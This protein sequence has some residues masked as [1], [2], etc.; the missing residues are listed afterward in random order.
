MNRSNTFGLILV[1][2]TSGLA[3]GGCTGTEAPEAH[4][5]YVEADWIYVASPQAGWIVEQP[6][7]EGMDVEAGDILFRLDTQAQEAALAEANARIAQSGAQARNM[8]T[9][10]REAEIRALQARLDEARA[11]LTKAEAD[12]TRILPL[13]ERGLEPQARGDTVS[14]EADMAAAAVAALTQDIAVARQA[15]RPAEREAADAL[16]VSAEAAR[17]SAAYRLSQRTVT[18]AVPGRVEG[19]FLKTG[20]YANPGAPIVALL[21]VDGLKVRFF[22]PQA[23]LPEVSLGQPV[24]IRADG[25]PA[26]IEATVSYIS[27]TAEYTPPVIY[28]KGSRDKL[29]FLVEARVATSTGL[30]PGLPIE[31]V[32]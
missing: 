8:S 15:A 29:V 32:W 26:S 9:G 5:G 17:D 3:L 18:A 28:S 20:E 16:T 10:A 21:P 2:A 30:K 1:V 22:V 12:K 11:R 13:V 27:S 25:L 19:V 24:T 31:V 23:Q 4:I 7:H 6:V 14:A